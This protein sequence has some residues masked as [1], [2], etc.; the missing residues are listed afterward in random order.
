MCQI[1]SYTLRCCGH[2]CET[3]VV[4]RCN[5]FSWETPCGA[6]SED[7][8]T[9][10][11]SDCIHCRQSLQGRLAEITREYRGREAAMSEDARRLEWSSDKVLELTLKIDGERADAQNRLRQLSGGEDQVVC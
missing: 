4:S 11:L 10:V 5:E 9:R 8:A 1:K 3:E 6:W 2:V 7:I